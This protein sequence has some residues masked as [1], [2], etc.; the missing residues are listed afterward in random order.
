MDRF[1]KARD[2][3]CAYLLTQLHDDGSFGDLEAGVLD[4]YKV[5]SA[6]VVCGESSAASRLCSWIRTHGMTSEGDYGPRPKTPY[7]YAYVYF[8]S[9]TIIGAHRLG[10]FDVSQRGMDFLMD[11]WDPESGGFYSS[12]TERSADTMQDLWIT[13]G[14]GQ[15]ALYTGR[16]DA[17]LGVGRWMNTLMRGQPNFPKQLFGVYSR[18][19]GVI[20]EPD[21]EDE[22]RYVLNYDAQKDSPF[23]NP[24]IAAGFLAR[25]YQ[26]TGERQWLDL[27][28]EYMT[29]TDN[30]SDYLF[31]LLRA[32]KVAWASSVLYTLTGRQKYRDTA[33]RVGDNLIATQ[34]EDGSWHG[35][36]DM[37][38]EPNNDITAEL[39]VWLD[40][41]HQAV[42]G[43]R[44]RG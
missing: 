8:N 41:V 19:R 39:V 31:R 24:G 7:D 44:A 37:P 38:D 4:Y 34:K 16:M 6:F 29:F 11:F 12:P 40:E 10:Q 15:A 27:A 25:L 26:A 43:S 30:A 22:F 14:A 35:I 33:I 28:E 17:A 13:S 18:S 42:G 3:G 9:W 1:A 21:P 20:T 2:R 5:P 32:G 23:Y 36:A